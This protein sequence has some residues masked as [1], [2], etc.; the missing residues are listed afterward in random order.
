MATF[1]GMFHVV[2]PCFNY[3]EWLPACVDSVLAS[4]DVDVRVTIVDDGSTDEATRWALAKYFSGSEPRVHVLTREN[5][6]VGAAMNT[7][8]GESFPSAPYILTL[9]ADDKIGSRYL[10]EAER[11]LDAGAD[12]VYPDRMLFGARIE[13]AASHPVCD[14][15]VLLTGNTVAAPSPFRR[16]LWANLGGFNEDRAQTYEDWEFWLRC[17]K[18]GATFKYLPGAHLFVRT[19]AGQ[20]SGLTKAGWRDAVT[21]LATLHPDLNPATPPDTEF[22]ADAEEAHTP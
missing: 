10:A 8:I 9:G 1:K 18:A 16:S 6:G 21:A 5:G 13:R 17:A 2:I 11:L 4:Q 22:L 19:H 7:G 3:G 20:R 14:L 15:D 12:I